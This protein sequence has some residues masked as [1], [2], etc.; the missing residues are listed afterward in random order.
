MVSP[1]EIMEMTRTLASAGPV[2]RPV[3]RKRAISLGWVMAESARA[4]PDAVFCIFE[5]RTVTWG[6]FDRQANR[7][8]HLL[9]SFGVARGDAVG[10]FME[11]RVEFLL[12]CVAL[13]RLGARAGLINTGVRGKSLL[14]CLESIGARRLLFGEELAEAVAEVRDELPF[15]PEPQRLLLV[16]DSASEPAPG[17]SLDVLGELEH[18]SGS[19]PEVT[20]DIRA[21]EI[22]FYI[23][24]S[25][26][27]GLPKA[28]IIT[29]ERW[30]RMAR[31]FTH[32]SL[33]MREHDRIYVCVPM[34]HS[35]G[36]YVGLGSVALS[37][38]SM[39][40][41]R[42]FSASSFLDETREYRTSRFVY[43]GELCRYL[44]NQPARP[45][46]GNNPLETITGNGLRPD[47][48]KAFRE[49]FNIPRIIEF[50]GAT[51]GNGGC[52]NLFNKDETVGFC[53]Q[54]HAL[55]KFDV[56]NEQ[57]IRDRRG[58][59]IR[60]E[61]GETG[62][63]LMKISPLARFEGYTSREATEKKVLRGV[64][65]KRDAWFNTGDLL[66]QVDVGFAL[67]LPHYQFV[68]RV[69][70]TFR[71]KGENVSTNEVA[72]LINESAEV[73]YSNV[74]GVTLPGTDGRAGMAA[75]VPTS[76]HPDLDALSEHIRRSLPHFA[77]PVFLRILPQ[78]DTTG[79]FKLKKTDLVREG[80]DP[81]RIGDPLYVLKPGSERYE[82]L[83]RE[84]H[85]RILAGQAGY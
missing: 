69:G 11:N 23:F 3:P 70:D 34:Y 26:T 82:A 78:M 68:D 61:K 10:V 64:F 80:H 40:L 7:L 25:G 73:E 45:D 28:S 71:W 47:I 53:A 63:M 15:E 74:Y 1:G 48:W 59:C 29:H 55:V 14:H 84:F 65:G 36:I 75:I 37:G 22:A 56:E 24:T 43:I 44:L 51:E 21:G 79:T 12:A 18:H 66:R 13:S 62:L 83:D 85:K 49:R 31:V 2:V 46:D 54:P 50:Y 17:E 77:Q 58:R 9:R 19:L 20:R 33:R 76:D 67:G 52:M 39:F 6:E 38:G 16:R 4:R 8:A 72:D 41:R 32:L 30:L 27:T 35:N 81:E 57:I 60:A 42:R 5:G